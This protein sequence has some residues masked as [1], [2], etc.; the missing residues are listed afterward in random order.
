MTK[1][2]LQMRL[3]ACAA[4]VYYC[5]LARAKPV[6]QRLRQPDSRVRRVL[7]GTKS[8]LAKPL[9]ILLK[10]TYLAS[11]HDVESVL[12]A[13]ELAKVALSLHYCVSELSHLASVAAVEY[14]ED[15]ECC[16]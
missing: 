5:H 7:R 9:I 4:V 8:L 3:V 13:T 16:K 6:V 14:D 10:P 1:D 11:I 12:V 2:Y 15:L